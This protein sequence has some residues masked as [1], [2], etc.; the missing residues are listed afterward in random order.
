MTDELLPET[1][2]RDPHPRQ[3]QTVL[4]T[5]PS[6]MLDGR[7]AEIGRWVPDWA[8][9][10]AKHAIDYIRRRL[11]TLP[12][13]DDV[14]Q[15]TLKTKGEG[16]DYDELRKMGLAFNSAIFIHASEIGPSYNANVKLTES[17]VKRYVKDPA[18]CAYDDC[19][20]PICVLVIG[21]SFNT[22]GYLSHLECQHCK[23]KWTA[24]LQITGVE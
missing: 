1:P 22:G 5:S 20:N 24:Q 10:S 21:V 9:H 13:D 16:Q 11:K 8:T 6:P 2:H 3:G 23:G 7:E 19:D 18:I 17:E 15:V 4:L 14:L 12:E